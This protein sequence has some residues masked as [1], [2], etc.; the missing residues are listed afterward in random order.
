MSWLHSRT[1]VD[2]RVPQLR[3]GPHRSADVIPTPERGVPES[4]RLAWSRINDLLKQTMSLEPAIQQIG[5]SQLQR[6]TQNITFADAR[7]NINQL[8][9][10]L[11]RTALHRTIL[12]NGIRI[13]RP[14]CRMTSLLNARCFS[15]L[16]SPRE[17]CPNMIGRESAEARAWVV[18]TTYRYRKATPPPHTHVSVIGKTR[19]H[20]HGRLRPAARSG[21]ECSRRVKQRGGW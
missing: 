14:P 12:H 3:S 11:V 10:K 7:V 19:P 1:V 18:D 17:K 6:L 16:C 2:N 21:R 4:L 9:F 15:D 8:R 20:I 5:L 13:Q